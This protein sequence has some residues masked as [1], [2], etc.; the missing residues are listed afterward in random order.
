M[1]NAGSPHL[2]GADLPE[3]PTSSGFVA[4][5]N[6]TAFRVTAEFDGG[7]GLAEEC[8]ARVR[9]SL[10]RNGF[11]IVDGLLTRR[12]AG[13][14][15]E[16]IERTAGDPTRNMS[17]F[18]SQTDNRYRRRNFCS[19]PSSPDTLRFVSTIC[20]RLEPVISEYCG[21]S[22]P[23]LE[24]TTLTSHQGCSHQYVHRDPDCVLSMFVAVED[25]APEQGG[26]LFVPGTHKFGGSN[27]RMGGRAEEFMELYRIAC[28]ARIFLYNLK[29]LLRMRREGNPELEPHEFRDR[30]FSRSRDD[31]QPNL[32]R[33]LTGRTFQFHFGMLGPGN[34]WKLFRYR[35]MLARSFSLVRTSPRKGSVIIYRSDI[36]HAGGDNRSRKARHLLSL[37]LGRDVIDPEQWDLSYSPDPTLRAAPRSYGDLLEEGDAPVPWGT[38]RLGGC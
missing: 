32:L 11:V 29:A 10:D 34:L 33:L 16:L 31:H 23:L 8:G 14:G 18:A 20:R 25:V 13:V 12:E 17:Q 2:A 35:K 26:T 3:R 36:L 21:R 27:L 1:P 38:A 15:Q 24:I 19:L 5:D 4:L 7:T 28:N 22:R 9:D 6:A 30:V 37:S